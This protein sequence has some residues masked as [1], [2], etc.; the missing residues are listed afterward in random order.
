LKHHTICAEIIIM[1]RKA[2]EKGAVQPDASVSYLSSVV[3]FVPFSQK[4]LAW[5]K[6]NCVAEKW[7]WESDNLSVDRRTADAIIQGMEAAGF[8]VVNE[9]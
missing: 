7:Q 6:K 2:K 9:G 4:A 3:L 5:L 1:K 8:V